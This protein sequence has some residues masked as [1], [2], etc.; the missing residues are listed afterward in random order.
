MRSRDSA[1]KQRVSSS[2]RLIEGKA[3]KPVEGEGMSDSIQTLEVINER[4]T[5]TM[6]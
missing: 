6:R 2:A 4:E 5:G 3:T 1:C